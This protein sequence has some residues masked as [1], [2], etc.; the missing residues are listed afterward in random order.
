M[1]SGSISFENNG[2]NSVKDL[3]SRR[4]FFTS[5]LQK[6]FIA[7]INLTV[8]LVNDKG[9]LRAAKIL[10]SIGNIHP[11]MKGAALMEKISVSK[12]FVEGFENLIPAA[13]D[14]PYKKIIAI[15]DCHGKFK[16]L[17][18]LLEKISVTDDK[19]LVFLGD[20]IDRGNEVAEMLTWIL[21]QRN[22]KNFIF[23]RGNHEQMLIDTLRGRMDKLTWLFNGGKETI[24]ALSKLKSAD[25][26]IVEKVVFFFE[27]LPLYHALNIG[28]RKFVF[29]H[30]GIDS[31][32]S[33]EEQKEDFL[34]WSREEFFNT[35]DGDAVVIGGH[36][37]VQFFPQFGVKDNPRPIRLPGRNVVLTD[38]GSF[39]PN[40]KISAVDVLSGEYW[41]SDL[42]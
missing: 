27:S 35:Y 16:R 21:E 23:L 14:T 10:T 1:A 17:M 28:G 2:T 40:G 9:K 4:N 13:N 24:Q 25:K 12:N 11:Q 37:P 41:Q 30:A 22:K 42:L 39:M 33:L 8:L 3:N 6:F 7:N 32:V 38:T 26:D 29:V 5:S 34:L 36:S 15:S 18:N 19:L 31:S 20:L